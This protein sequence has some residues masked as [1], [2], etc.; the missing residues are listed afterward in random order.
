[1]L[2][3]VFV[4]PR[5]LVA[6][7]HRVDRHTARNLPRLLGARA[8]A[9]PVITNFTGSVMAN[10]KTKSRAVPQRRCATRVLYFPTAPSECQISA[11]NVRPPSRE[12]WIIT[13]GSTPCPTARPTP[14]SMS[15]TIS[16]TVTRS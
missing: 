12:I 13:C 1:L 7:G 14:V 11:P 3:P 8:H 9:M 5:E 2:L 4:A 16:S 6:L 15:A 10:L